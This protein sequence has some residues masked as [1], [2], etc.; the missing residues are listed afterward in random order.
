L[1]V[2]LL[3]VFTWRGTA[4]AEEHK[5]REFQ[6]CPE[7]PVM[8]GIPAGKFPM[9]SPAN[10]SGRFDSEGPQHEVAIK[11]FALGKYD[12]TSEQFL[13]FLKET[14]YRPAPCNPMLNMGWNPPGGGHEGSP[15]EGDLPRWP[16]VCLDWRDA[17]KYIDW[18]NAKIGRNH[19][20]IAAAG[21]YRLPT[22]AEWEYA[23]R[24]GTKTAR[25][26][27]DDIGSGNA[28]CNGCGSQWDNRLFADVDSFA[29]NPFGLY[30][31]L[32]N[33]WQWTAD[34]WHSNYV[35][36]PRDGSAWSEADCS[37]R[38]IRGGSWHN[39]PVFVRSA[40]RVGI[41][42]DGGEPDYSGLAGFR[43]ARDLP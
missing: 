14:G 7:C 1:A 28:N 38:V 23:A 42:R 18:L 19:A 15:Y 37:T 4:G 13:T 16:A 20:G 34:C 41:G 39:L 11:A 21:P 22:E 17:E 6:E 40:A 5:D 9:G 29:P 26:W 25:W 32:G 36:A 3:A 12:V 33:A 30:G 2:S 35:G 31:I 43:V 27:G 10:E 24:G 8:I